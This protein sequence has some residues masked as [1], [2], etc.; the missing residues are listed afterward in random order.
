MKD[1]DKVWKS[2]R[3]G[4]NMSVIQSVKIEKTKSKAISN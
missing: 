4:K 3:A 2:R 1:K